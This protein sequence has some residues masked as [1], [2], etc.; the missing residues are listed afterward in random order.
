MNIISNYEQQT[1]RKTLESVCCCNNNS[2][3]FRNNE[4]ALPCDEFSYVVN[5]L[6]IGSNEIT[7][8]LF[9]NIGCAIKVWRHPNRHFIQI[10]PI[11]VQ[12]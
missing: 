11:I 8:S 12:I 5:V 4:Q 10:I 7:A 1:V 9:F 3:R 6:A 2:S